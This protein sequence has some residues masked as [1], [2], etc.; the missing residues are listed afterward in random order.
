MRRGLTQAG[1]HDITLDTDFYNQYGLDFHNQEP[2][3][4]KKCQELLEQ[5]PSITWLKHESA[6]IDLVS[7][8]GPHTTFNIFGSPFSPASGKWAF[9]YGH[10]E[11]SLLWDRIPLDTDIVVT[12]TPPKYHCDRSRDRV[13]AGCPALREALWRVRPRLAVCGHIHEGRGAERVSWDLGHSHIAYKESNTESWIDPG[14]GNKKLSLVD[15]TRKSGSAIDN[16]GSKGDFT[17]N[18]SKGDNFSSVI[19]PT[20]TTLTI[21]E[22][23]LEGSEAVPGRI[24]NVKIPIYERSSITR[25]PMAP[26]TRGQGGVPP[27]LKCDL[28]ALSGRMGRRETCIINAAIMAS[29]WPHEGGKK[30]NKPIIVDIDLPVWN[31][32]SIDKRSP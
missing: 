19:L 1:N 8:T 13:A 18:V 10:E 26:A 25:E 29:S 24:G 12:H 31:E 16:D 5:S 23:P 22:Q 6:T 15:L 32:H 27:S 2:Q 21:A 14:L 17:M 3:D 30:F 20:T 11:A 9:G 28:E 7:P 4:P